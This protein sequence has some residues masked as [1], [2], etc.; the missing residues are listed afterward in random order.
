MPVWPTRADEYSS[1]LER[2][3]RVKDFALSFGAV[4]PQRR[5]RLF[6]WMTLLHPGVCI[7][8]LSLSLKMLFNET[9]LE[10]YCNSIIE[11]NLS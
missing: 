6:P 11:D 7:P 9:V 5:R 1:G 3:I 10:H 4:S 8:S 2:D